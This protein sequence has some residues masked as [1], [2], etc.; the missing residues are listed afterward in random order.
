VEIDPH[1][2]LARVRAFA[3]TPAGSVALLV[4]AGTIAV[5]AVPFW[6]LRRADATAASEAFVSSPEFVVWVLIL[7]GQAAVWVGAAAYVIATVVR[8][9]RDLRAQDALPRAAVAAIAI[10]AAGIALVTV[11]LLFGDRLGLYPDYEGPRGLPKGSEWPLYAH[12]AKVTP[13]VATA[14]LIGIL[15]IAGMWL[16]AVGFARLA[17]GAPASRERVQRFV[18]LR[19]ELTTLLAVTALLIGLAT[20]A[21]GALREAVLAENRLP[22]YRDAAIG[23]IA[24]AGGESATSVR[25]RFDE[26]SETYPE[27][28]EWQFDRR[29]VLAYGLLFSAV[30]ALA[31]APVFIVMRR[32]GDRLRDDT[33][34]LPDP[35]DPKFFDSVEKRRAFDALLQ[36]NLSSTIVFKAGAAILTP[37]A[38]SLVSTLVPT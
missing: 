30:L 13:F 31:F 34:V 33:Y 3:R 36:T 22:A 9:V 28:L 37:L 10:A 24:D 26:L 29:Y 27:C 4:L 23:C 25:A 17:R 5:A 6:V 12:Q 38:A 20:L 1:Q 11:L 16:T 7:C 21:S 15:A 8:R 18:A 2:P 14:I 32:A 35:S 19:A